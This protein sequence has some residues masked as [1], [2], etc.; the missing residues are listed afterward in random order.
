M[1]VGQEPRIAQHD[2]PPA[3][4]R[5][6]GDEN[7]LAGRQ[8]RLERVTPAARGTVVIFQ[9]LGAIHSRGVHVPHELAAPA[10][11]PPP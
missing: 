2:D 8:Q 5:A 1:G 6:L 11:V 10:Q 7:S 9:V 4:E 3:P